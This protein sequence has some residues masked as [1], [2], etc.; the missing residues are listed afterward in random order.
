MTKIKLCG[1]MDPRDIEVINTLSADYAG[2]VFWEKSRRFVSDEKA[3]SLKEKLSKDI[4]AVGVFLDD[5]I[6]HIKSLSDEGIIDVIQLHGHEDEGYISKLKSCTDMP[7]IKAFLVKDESVLETIE[8]SGA[9]MVLLDSG[10]GSGKSFDWSIL[11]KIK[12]DYFLA[13]GLDTKNVA[14]AV[15]R[16]RP[17]AVDVS[18]GIE[19]DG[20][21]DPQKMRRFVEEVR[22]VG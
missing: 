1:M 8:A 5:D 18:S 2:F 21:K 16:L 15:E 10:T 14:E 3:A 12:R 17:Y 4:K 9:D 19:T 11:N 7:I 6:D 22:H 20:V 13:G